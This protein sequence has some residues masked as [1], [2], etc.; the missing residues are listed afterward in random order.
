HAKIYLMRFLSALYIID[1]DYDNAIIT[2]L[3][4]MELS[5]KTGDEYYKNKSIVD[6]AILSKN[7]GGNENANEILK[8]VDT[9]GIKD[10]TKRADL[11]IY[12]DM[13]LAQNEISLGNTKEAKKYLN[14]IDKHLKYIKNKKVRAIECLKN[15]TMAELLI[16]ENNIEESEKYLNKAKVDLEY[17][18]STYAEIDIY[19]DIVQ[20]KVYKS[21]KLYDKAL[22]QADMAREKI[23]EQV[24]IGYYIKCLNIYTEIYGETKDNENLVKYTRES[25]EVHRKLSELTAKSHYASV[26]YKV[27]YNKSEQS[28]EIIGRFS[29]LSILIIVILLCIVMYYIIYPLIIK[30]RERKKVRLYIKNNNYLLNY[31]PIVNP[32][33]SEI[34]GFEGLLR[35]KLEDKIIF[36]NVIISQI[37]QTNMMGEV[38]IWILNQLI[39]DYKEISNID[40]INK[41]FYISM[42]I[43]LKEIE[44]DKICEVLANMLKHSNLSKNSICIEITE[45]ELGKDHDKIS[46]NIKKLKEA[47][48]II[49]ID[50]FG[51]DYSNLSFIDKFEFNIIKLDKY[52][53]DNIKHSIAVQSL[54]DA[55]SYI[56]NKK[57]ISI[58][59]E[60]VEEAKQKEYIKNI[61]LDIF[62]I[63]GYY[64]S[65]PVDID[66]I[67]DIKIK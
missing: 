51:V 17:G 45:N 50:D 12:V 54:M 38:S 2:H 32:Q 59:V 62:F 28:K 22:E 20:A 35:L 13:N 44:N 42:N 53:I 23:S 47:G 41:D 5:E 66:K 67:K 3:E 63:Q 24:N 31:Q 39:K 34:I 8:S 30:L 61:D 14:D 36:P 6:I 33:N 46:E 29:E 57:G 10:E 21:K 9:T 52:F 26:L 4:I 18:M 48:F 65:K 11:K 19:F 56:A 40:N 58:V 27:N 1:F 16:E 60:G 7:L 37:E 64:Y 43:S 49:A 55:V 25:I 15:I